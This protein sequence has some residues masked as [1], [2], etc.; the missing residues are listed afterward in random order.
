[1]P[2]AQVASAPGKLVLV[3]EYAVLE[4]GPAISAAVNIFATATLQPATQGGSELHIANCGGQYGFKV[5]P[6]GALEWLADPGDRGALLA[7]ALHTLAARG[8]LREGL[9]PVRL[10]LCTRSFYSAENIGVAQK[11]GIGSS[12]AMAVALT[13]AL[14]SFLGHAPAF[15]VCLDTHRLF[16]R[17]KGSGVDVATSWF[18]GVIA[19]QPRGADVPAVEQLAWPQ[20]L[21]VVPVWTGESASTTAML[22]QLE[23]FKERSEKT[24]RSIMQR[25][26]IAAENTCNHWRAGDTDDVMAALDEFGN[27]LHELDA[28][29]GIGI[30]SDGH[31]RLNTMAREFGVGYKPSG[32]GGGDFGL[33]YSRD[34]SRLQDLL[35]RVN[36]EL[37]AQP[38]RLAWTDRGLTI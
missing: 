3:G 18:G 15:D 22:Q 32:A 12:A 24:C 31:I 10:E 21:N 13:S 35:A 26:V 8:Y 30:W 14:Q 38:A 28:A 17:G 1:M 9:P 37:V 20:G 23:L 2:R 5:G 27:L 11:I 4:G 19:M 33:A 7:A 25:M 36:S 6:R 16:Q 29:A 34:A